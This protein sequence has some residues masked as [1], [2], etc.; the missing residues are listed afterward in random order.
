IA[1]PIAMTAKVDRERYHTSLL[2]KSQ[3]ARILTN[4]LPTIQMDMVVNEKSLMVRGFRNPLRRGS[5]VGVSLRRLPGSFTTAS[6]GSSWCSFMFWPSLA[7]GDVLPT[8]HVR[9]HHAPSVP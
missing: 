3:M 5:R 4:T 7:G 9:G 8:W 2:V 6:R 1:V